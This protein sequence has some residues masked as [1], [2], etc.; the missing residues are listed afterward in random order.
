MGWEKRWA[1]CCGAF[2]NPHEGHHQGIPHPK[3]WPLAWQCCFF[4]REAHSGSKFCCRFGPHTSEIVPLRSCLWTCLSF[5][6]WWRNMVAFSAFG[7]WQDWGSPF[8]LKQLQEK[9][10]WQGVPR[11]DV[12]SWKTQSASREGEPPGP[13]WLLPSWTRS[14]SSHVR[15]IFKNILT[16]HEN[17]FS[18]VPIK[19]YTQPNYG[20]FLARGAAGQKLTREEG[21]EIAFGGHCA[22]VDACCCHPRL[23]KHKLQALELWPVEKYMMI[24]KFTPTSP[25]LEADCCWLCRGSRWRTQ[26]LNWSGFS[27]VASLLCSSPSF[28]NWPPMCPEQLRQSF[29]ILHLRPGKIFIA[30][31]NNPEFSR[32]SEAEVLSRLRQRLGDRLQTFVFDGGYVRCQSFSEEVAG[33]SRAQQCTRMDYELKSNGTVD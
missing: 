31:E 30:P 3:S 19:Y 17:A 20:R 21:R 5:L 33:C 28:G 15:H 25:S 27:M 8:D 6:C 23:L 22:E 32:F 26:R 16:I 13:T 29:S 11:C 9:W 24:E 7:S 12:R 2:K 18:S 1:G 4:Q 14:P 10:G